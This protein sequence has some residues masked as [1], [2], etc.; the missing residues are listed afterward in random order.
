[1]VHKKG[2]RKR[3]GPSGDAWVFCA[4]A[5]GVCV[6]DGAHTMVKTLRAG[7]AAADRPGPTMGW[8]STPRPAT[9]V[10]QPIEAPSRPPAVTEPFIP[11]IVLL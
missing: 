6:D 3:E 5:A 2:V 7:A 1:M 11:V 4:L 9:A 10:P 8:C